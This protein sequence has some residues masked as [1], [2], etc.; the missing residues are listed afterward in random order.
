MASPGMLQNGNSR[1]LFVKWSPDPKNGIVFTGYSVEGTLAK[2][3]MNRPKTII[4]NEQTIEM[5]LSVEYISFSAHADYSHTAEYIKMLQPPNI[6]LVHG[7]ANEMKKLQNDLQS[8]YKEKI[9][10]LTP[11]N[12]QPVRLKLVTKKTAKIVG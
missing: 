9:K 8:R 5:K 2:Q 7:D 11:K 12:C 6:V 1:D 4:V 10:V 3:V